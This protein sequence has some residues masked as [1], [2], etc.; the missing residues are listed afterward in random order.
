MVSWVT[1]VPVA[2]VRSP[3]VVLAAGAESSTWKV[4]SAAGAPS[5]AGAVVTVT[6]FGAVSSAAQTRRA[7]TAV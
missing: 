2:L 7:V 4:F 5:A 3:R 1:I 6:V